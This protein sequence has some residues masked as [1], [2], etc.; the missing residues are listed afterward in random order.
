MPVLSEM[1]TVLM[2]TTIGRALMDYRSI[3]TDM[4]FED[5]PA[6]N[7]NNITKQSRLRDINFLI[8]HQM[9][10]LMSRW[11]TCM[12]YTVC[13]IHFNGNFKTPYPKV[14]HG[15]NGISKRNFREIVMKENR[16]DQPGRM[17]MSRLSDCRV[18]TKKAK[19][20]SVGI[21][22]YSVRKETVWIIIGKWWP[23]SIWW[24]Q[25]QHQ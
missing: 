24:E 14:R 7:N 6:F 15:E 20:L 2:I 11:F 12:T 10:E 9:C 22:Q 16:L 17:Q 5:L 1:E 13:P 3:W 18:C 4:C 19:C 21:Q 23:P 25:Q 8:W